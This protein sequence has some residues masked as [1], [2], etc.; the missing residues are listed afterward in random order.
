MPTSEITTPPL[1]W[2]IIGA[3][4]FIMAIA[5]IAF[6]VDLYRYFFT[7]THRIR[8]WVDRTRWWY[9]DGSRVLRRHT[10]PNDPD[11]E[12][13]VGEWTTRAKIVREEYKGEQRSILLT[14]IT[15]VGVMFLSFVFLVACGFNGTTRTS[16][17]VDASI[18]EHYSLNSKPERATLFS[19]NNRLFETPDGKREVRADITGDTVVL[20]DTDGNVV[21]DSQYEHLTRDDI[22]RFVHDQTRLEDSSIDIDWWSSSSMYDLQN[23]PAVDTPITATGVI[24]GQTAKI[25]ITVNK[26]GDFEAVLDSAS[27][28]GLDPDQ[29]IR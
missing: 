23:T 28:K 18:A 13:R 15:S 19:V 9:P 22:A 26:H 5:L 24:D 11:R 17:S 4:L 10:S 14:I 7:R 1:G 21:D 25:L 12:K 2:V 20:R 3:L 29:V 6:S 16:V 27:S 8:N